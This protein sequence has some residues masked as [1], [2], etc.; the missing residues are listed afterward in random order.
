[1]SLSHRRALG[2]AAALAV[3]VAPVALL[4][5][6]ASASTPRSAHANGNGTITLVGP[7]SKS[8][9]KAGA[10]SCR[11]VNGRYVMRTVGGR[12]G[13]GM[14]IRLVIGNYTGAGA[15][16]GRVRV[17]Q[18]HGARFHGRILRGVP[19][20]VTSSGGSVQYSKT[21]SGKHNQALAGKTV[22]VS[23]SWTCSA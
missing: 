11:V 10:V 22:S 4:V 1:M 15:Y 19:V 5:S 17:T 20:T 3:G 21:L 2:A 7:N 9:T 13:Q 6:S 18:V 23:A 12:P 16:T 8:H 14:R